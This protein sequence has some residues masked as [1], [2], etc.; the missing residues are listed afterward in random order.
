MQ[1]QSKLDIRNVQNWKQW[2]IITGLITVL[3]GSLT[4][5]TVLLT[6][7]EYQVKAVYLFNFSKFTR[8]PAAAFNNSQTPIRICVLGKNPF[9][10]FNVLVKNKI[11]KKRKVTVEQLD[12]F[13]KSNHCH[14]LF[15]SKSEQGDQA[16]ILAYT[17]Q[18][19]VL[20][21]SDIKNFVVRG[22]MVQFYFRGRKVRFMIDP[23]T[24]KE[25]GLSASAN[26]LRV[27]KI[28]K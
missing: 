3:V 10:D 11:V 18:Y 27:A 8:W 23:N 7:K 26:L 1:F 19:P 16:A 4:Y 2:A 6:P 14:I 9:D 21:V 24:L 20:T 13:R 12:D 22:G 28:V 17:K 5:A 25:A 15:V